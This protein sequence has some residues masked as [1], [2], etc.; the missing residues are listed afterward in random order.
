MTKDQ[1]GMTHPGTPA[2]PSC[3]GSLCRL[4]SGMLGASG[5][6]SLLVVLAL[7][8][9]LVVPSRAQFSLANDLI[10][11]DSGTRLELRAVFDPLPPTGYVPVRAVITSGSTRAS[12]WSF[13]FTSQTQ[14]FRAHNSHRSRFRVEVPA[15]ATQSAA[16]LVPMA[17]EY[18]NRHGG[19]SS[20]AP[21]RVEVGA[22]GHGLRSYAS[23]ESRMRGFPAIAIS[24]ELAD[25]SITKLNK[26]L[27]SRG[28]SGSHFFGGDAEF[29][30]QFKLDDLPED[31]RGWSGFDYALFSH[32][33]WARLRPAARRA[34]E[35]WVRLGGNLHIYAPAEVGS[36]VLGLPGGAE[37]LKGPFGLGRLARREWN[38]KELPDAATVGHYWGLDRRET[39]LLE[40]RASLAR[41]TGYWPL[42]E[43]IGDR[44]FASWQVV[45]FLVVFGILVGPVNLFVLAPSGRR[46][47][48]FVTTPLLSVG[49]SLLMVAVIL[50]QDGTGGAGARFAAVSLHPEDATACVTQE[51]VSRTGV[52]FSGAFETRQPALM[53]PVTMPP[54]P[55]VK[56]HSG[57]NSPSVELVEDGTVR[58][59]NWFQSRAEQGQI[60]RAVLST[61]ARIER[62]AGADP[63]SA[64][65]LVSAL[66]FPVTR[67]YYVDDKGDAW[68]APA[69]LASGAEVSLVRCEMKEL[70]DA[71]Q[72]AVAPAG[73]LLRRRL[74]E[75][76]SGAPRGRFF[77]L[78][79]TAPAFV[80]DTLPAIRWQGGGVVLHGPVVVP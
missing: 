22:G 12:V 16:F 56:L 14:A 66:G 13:D 18:G 78:A 55:W 67:L 20:G 61:R 75:Q 7:F 5:A 59:G 51:Q 33:D 3:T 23:H 54:R 57:H 35:Q 17:V 29:G 50:I 10:D 40:G 53:E 62:K 68:K 26:E 38:G 76:A 34:V 65:A 52:L 47:R 2:A 27:K 45:L 63:A 32:T 30:S 37:A 36:D 43:A 42:V 49:A 4:A 48:L 41:G 39:D 24:P 72:A 77:A 79:D 1:Y 25:S 6:Q 28:S 74:E 21:L 31:W 9:V 73:Q 44:S 80:L 46:H 69:A 60:L 70:R 64:P 19:F 11:K 71:W 15:R 8:V 58:S